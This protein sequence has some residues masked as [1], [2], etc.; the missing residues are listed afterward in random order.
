MKRQYRLTNSAA[1]KLNQEQL[2]LELK[3]CFIEKNHREPSN[4]ESNGMHEAAEWIK[5]NLAQ[6]RVFERGIEDDT[7]NPAEGARSALSEG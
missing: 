2:L 3:D 5:G 1:R 7:W 6:S 4:E